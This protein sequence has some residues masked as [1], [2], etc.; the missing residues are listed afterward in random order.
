MTTHSNA[1]TGLARTTVAP[2]APT[3]KSSSASTKPRLRVGIGTSWKHERGRF[4]VFDA[5]TVLEANLRA[6]LS[7]AVCTYRRPASLKRLLNSLK[8]QNRVPDELIIVDASYDSESEKV[9]RAMS[10]VETLASCV[11]YVRVEGNLRGLTRQRNLAVDV[12]GRE[13]ICFLDDDVVVE[14][15]CLTHLETTAAEEPH[16]VGV[17]AFVTNEETNP[18]ARLQLLKLLGAVPSLTPG[19]YTRS[20]IS[21][22]LRI[23]GKSRSLVPVDRLPGCC[24]LCRTSV[25]RLTRFTEIFEGYSL[26]EDLEFSRRAAAFGRLVVC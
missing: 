23:L 21:I 17:G 20:G 1:H 6:G 22:P 9:V 10:Q 26:G 14:P 18:G 19:K 5:S 15:D 12:A 3:G 8:K 2:S 4:E 25:A 13:L 11:I 24:F 7:V 16:V